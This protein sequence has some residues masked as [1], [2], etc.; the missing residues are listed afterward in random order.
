[1]RH[2][3]IHDIIQSYIYIYIYIHV[4]YIIAL[5][6]TLGDPNFWKPIRWLARTHISLASEIGDHSTIMGIRFLGLQGDHVAYFFLTPIETPKI[7]PNPRHP[8]LRPSF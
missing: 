7:H 2:P 3:A 1:M 8:Q 5:T 6:L 4:R